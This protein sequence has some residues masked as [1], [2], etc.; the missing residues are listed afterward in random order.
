MPSFDGNLA[1]WFHDHHGIADA[2]V[3][4]QHG[5]SP[6]Q[7][8]RLVREGVLEVLFEGVC[9]LTSTP[10][11]LQ[12]RCAAV[13]AADRSLVV[14]CFTA[15]ALDGLRRCGSHFLHV[16]TDRATKPVGPRVKVH[17]TRLLPAEHI[18]ARPD[19]IRLTAPERTFFDIAKH[20]GDL[21][22]LSIGEQIIRDGLATY[23]SLVDVAHS[24]SSRGRPGSGR[25][26]RVLA[27]RSPNGTAAES[28]DEVKLLDALHRA[29]LRH[30]VRHPAVTLLSGRTIHPDIGDPVVGFFVE[31]DH[32]TWHDPS[33]AI[34][35]DNERD[36]QIRLAGGEVERVTNTRL[37]SDLP[38]V[39]A[40]ILQLYHCRAAQVGVHRG[41]RPA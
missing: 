38:A 5:L 13:C 7:R 23:D 16:T 19:G 12:A 18:V 28:H 8:Q 15:G 27:G 2:A 29:G 35:A 39:V 1:R 30:F 25:A 36:R 26:L 9:H 37:D 11:D 21:T 24:M 14:S 41:R 20:V 32:H 6:D 17:R 31:V 4:S 34:D 3:L 40:D 22:L 10:L 33:A